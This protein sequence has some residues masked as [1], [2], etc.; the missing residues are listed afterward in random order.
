MVLL[1]FLKAIFFQSS[2][3]LEIMNKY[4][5][6]QLERQLITHGWWNKILNINYKLRRIK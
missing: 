5:L 6:K 2:K 3:D 4:K 1:K